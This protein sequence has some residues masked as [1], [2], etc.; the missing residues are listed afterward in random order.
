MVISGRETP[1]LAQT[2]SFQ[3]RSEPFLLLS[4]PST[5]GGEPGDRPSAAVAWSGRGRGAV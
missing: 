3:Q 4:D 1:A 2:A 5:P